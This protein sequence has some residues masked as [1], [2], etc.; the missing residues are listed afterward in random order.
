MEALVLAAAVA[1]ALPADGPI[2]LQGFWRTAAQRACLARDLSSHLNPAGAM[3]AF[4]AGLLQDMAIPVLAAAFPDRYTAVYHGAGDEGEPELCARERAEFGFDHAEI[5]TMMAEAWDLPET[6]I[7][8]IAH[9]HCD[10]EGALAAVTAVARVRHV[11]PTD[12][13]AVFREHCEGA[14]GLPVET[15]DRLVETAERE[16]ASLAE[17]MTPGRG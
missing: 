14:L 17:S 4:T 5:G 6:L 1:D 8:G 11:E 3:E 13:L 9:H 10:G 2:D 15:V 7:A 12:G 16:A